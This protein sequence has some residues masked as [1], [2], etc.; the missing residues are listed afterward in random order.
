MQLSIFINLKR[1]NSLYILFDNI[2][3]RYINDIK[4]NQTVCKQ[5]TDN[6]CN[7]TSYIPIRHCRR[8][9]ILKLQCKNCKKNSLLYGTYLNLKYFPK[10]SQNFLLCKPNVPDFL[11]HANFKLW[12]CEGYINLMCFRLYSKYLLNFYSNKIRSG[13]AAFCISLEIIPD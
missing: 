3:N 13:W 9:F 4:C 12:K 2:V 10:F 7:E 6:Y 1:N 5:Q 11:T 8:G